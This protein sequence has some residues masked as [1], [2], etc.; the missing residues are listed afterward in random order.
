MAIPIQKLEGKYEILEKI[1]EG[2]MG[3][4]Y[5][6]RHRLLG[7]E[8]VVKVMR[9]H[10]QRD[11]ELQSRFLAEA[12]AATQLSHPNIAQIFDCTID[13]D[14]FAYI[15]MEFIRGRSLDEVLAN[16]EPLRL[17]LALEIAR[18]SLRA[19]GHIHQLNVAHRDISPDNLMLT[20]DI[21]ARLLVKV[22]DLGVAKDIDDGGPA[23]GSG[24]FLG[25]LRYAAPETFDDSTEVDRRHC[26][27]YAFGLVLYELLTGHFPIS[28][29]TPSSLIAGHLFRPPL[30]FAVTDPDGR[31]PGP[32]R[33]AVLTALAKHP[34]ERHLDA[35]SFAAALGSVSAAE[36]SLREVEELLQPPPE[37]ASV[38][39]VRRRSGSTQG[40]LNRQFLAEPTPLPDV[41]TEDDPGLDPTSPTLATAVDTEAT[42]ILSI[43]V[44]PIAV[45]E[46]MPPS[47]AVASALPPEAAAL[48]PDAR[49]SADTLATRM[50]PTFEL[51]IAMARQ[52]SQQH[53]YAEAV[54]SL[55]RA[56]VLAPEE[57]QIR[58][59]LN[60]ARRALHHQQAPMELERAIVERVGAISALLQD[61]QLDEAEMEL[62][63]ASES[64][65]DDPRW[66]TLRQ[67]LE[68][69]RRELAQ[70]TATEESTLLL[71]PTSPSQP[72][73]MV[74][75]PADPAVAV[76]PA[77][78][79]IRGLR[80]TG[81]AGEALKELNQAVR[82]FGDL[83]VL[84]TLRYELGEALLKRDAEEEETASQMFE[85]VERPTVG[86]Q[87]ILGDAQPILPSIPSSARAT[88]TGRGEFA[89]PSPQSSSAP[90]RPGLLDATIRSSSSLELPSTER[91]GPPVA[92]SNR[93]MILVGWILAAVL[94]LVVYVLS[95]QNSMEN[96]ALEV[97]DVVAADLSP[98]VL[99]I[100]AVPWG[101]IIGLVNSD[102]EEAPA[103][104]PS[105]FTPVVLRLPPGEYRITVRYPPSGRTEERVVTMTSDVQVEEHITFSDFDSDRYFEQIGW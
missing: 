67:Q 80:D 15:V 27:L 96:H 48:P 19:L 70:T 44:I 8:R 79:R 59:M 66:S 9:P 97:Q 93:N 68:T 94:A 90:P 82:D 60:E 54:E 1:Q 35:A 46:P 53:K 4:I 55:E 13:E 38:T 57:P 36:I 22:I 33:Q 28:G 100:D 83:S 50:M 20:R 6:V 21:E 104:Q 63:E 76:A 41:R 98:G 40:R 78:E 42:R 52:A 12:R 86:E 32:V 49:P 91:A 101:E 71:Q 37:M 30:D 47:P 51:Q 7:E 5:R 18:Q 74:I 72:T 99:L 61:G 43:P 29:E 10:L 84:Q 77:V 3:A 34:N 45:S 95:R 26:D 65:G 16:G 56:L 102:L 103:L 73:T 39:R 62:L 24:V 75:L 88:P 11:P 25:K 69:R 89:P 64:L 17:P 14:G 105:R 58:P 81:Q 87:Q 2:G 85:A 92:H 31:V 23:T